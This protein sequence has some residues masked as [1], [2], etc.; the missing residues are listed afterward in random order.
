MDEADE[1]ESYSTA[2]AARHLDLIDNTFVEHALRLL[3]G[4]GVEHAAPWGLDIGTGP[5]LIP[6]KLLRHLPE[7]RIVAIDRSRTML[8]R[9]RQNASEAGV[10]ARLVLALA[11]GHLLPFRNFAFQMVF[12]NSVLHHAREPLQLLREMAR[13]TAPGAPVLIRDLRRPSRLLLRAHL[14]RH[15]R[16]YGGLM[17]KLFDDSVRAAYTVEEL[18]ALVRES[19]IAGLSTFRFGGVHIGIEGRPHRSEGSSQAFIA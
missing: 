16:R 3:R 10:S 11:D 18:D 17:R 4:S 2:A 9:A 7:L 13:V 6:I 8:E 1:V 5:G 14:W 12:C 15:G 19:G